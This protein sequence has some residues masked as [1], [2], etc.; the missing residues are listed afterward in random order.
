MTNRMRVDMKHLTVTDHLTPASTEAFW[1][2]VEKS[3]DGECWHWAGRIVPS[4]Y[5]SFRSGGHLL[6]AHRVAYTLS[7]GPI[8]DGLS[9]DHLCRNRACVN[10]AHLEPVSNQENVRRGLRSALHVP[11]S[12]C[13]KGHSIEGDNAM[14]TKN[15]YPRC[16]QCNRDY[17]RQY[18]RTYKTK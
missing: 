6:T 8:P 12:T 4:G 3:A 5:G 1:A 17:M 7:T 18:M 10:P 11:A 13:T 15:G 14:P 16:R 9:L 2:L